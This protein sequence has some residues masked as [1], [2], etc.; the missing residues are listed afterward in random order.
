LTDE[1]IIDED[2]DVL[3][4]ALEGDALIEED[5]DA[6]EKVVE[7]GLAIPFDPLKKYLAE[8]SKYPVLSRDEELEVA[9]KIH[10]DKDR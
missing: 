7:K 4:E 3:E 8:I 5:E 6:L 1:I 10:T 9:V 2:E